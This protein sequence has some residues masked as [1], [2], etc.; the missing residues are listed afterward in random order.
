[1]PLPSLLLL[2]LNLF[3]DMKR[4]VMKGRNAT[5]QSE[6][7]QN[8]HQVDPADLNMVAEQWFP[9]VIPQSRLA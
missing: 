1:V 6:K 2:I 5:P 3:K 9:V 4:T 8:H 7:Q